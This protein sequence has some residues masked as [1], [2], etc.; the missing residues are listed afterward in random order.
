MSGETITPAMLRAGVRTIF[1]CEVG[2]CLSEEL[3]KYVYEAM[4]EARVP[5]PT[6]WHPAAQPPDGERSKWT[7][8]VIVVTNLGNVQVVSCFHGDDGIAPASCWQRPHGTEAGE[9]PEWWCEFPTKT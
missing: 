7:R 6:H 3:A 9:K 2:E 4:A 8:R 5:Q 1:D